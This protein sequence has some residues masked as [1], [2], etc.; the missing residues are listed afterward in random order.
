[1]NGYISDYSR[2]INF[3][4]VK[5]SS[6]IIINDLFITHIL[7]SQTEMIYVRLLYFVDAVHVTRVWIVLSF[8]LMDMVKVIQHKQGPCVSQV[9]QRYCSWEHQEDNHHHL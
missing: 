6:G 8:G 7:H 9:W 1:M 5:E 4:V 2:K 3:H